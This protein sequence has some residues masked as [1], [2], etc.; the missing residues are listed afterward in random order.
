MARAA[1]TGPLDQASGSQDT[2]QASFGLSRLRSAAAFAAMPVMRKSAFA[3][4]ATAEIDLALDHLF[5]GTEQGADI[6]R[7]HGEGRAQG[8]LRDRLL[9]PARSEELSG[10][11]TPGRSG[12]RARPAAT[13]WGRLAT[14]KGVRR[15]IPP[16]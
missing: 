15:R 14:A 5:V 2:S 11:P 16:A 7:E 8:V 4:P 12:R 1:P 13:R 6:Q 9:R 3:S 10:G